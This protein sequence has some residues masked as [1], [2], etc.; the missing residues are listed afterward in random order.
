M[1]VGGLT[2]VTLLQVWDISKYLGQYY[3]EPEPQPEPV[4]D[5]SLLPLFIENLTDNQETIMLRRKSMSGDTIT[6]EYSY[7]NNEWFTGYTGD[8]G[9]NISLPGYSRVYLRSNVSAWSEAGGK[10]HYIDAD[11]VNGRFAVGGNILSLT[12]GSAFNGQ[13]TFKNNTSATFASIFRNFETLVSAENLIIPCAD[14]ERCYYRTFEGC[15]SLEI[16]PKLL[17]GALGEECYRSMFNGCTS[18]ITANVIEATTCDTDSC[19]RMFAGCTSLVNVPSVLS[20]I[21]GYSCYREMYTGCTSLTTAPVLPRAILAGYS[22]Y[23]MFEGC[24][25]LKNVTCLATYGITFNH[26]TDYWM[27][28]VAANGTFTKD[29]EAVQW[30]RDMSGIPAT[31]TVVDY[32]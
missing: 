16:A 31:W 2:K 12:Y 15:T 3:V 1:G 7:D 9:T 23:R 29:A 6:V 28:G 13:Q 20:A 24:S 21:V 27:S 14:N 5:Y 26:N 22:Y 4:I 25:S 8:N 18:L 10:D 30:Y 11:S 32:Q 19:Y 17:G